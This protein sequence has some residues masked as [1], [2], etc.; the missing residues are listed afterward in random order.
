MIKRIIVV[1][2]GTVDL[3]DLQETLGDDTKI[4]V[5][6]Q[7]SNPPNILELQEPARYAYENER[8]RNRLE[9]EVSSL[10][11]RLKSLLDENNYLTNALNIARDIICDKCGKEGSE[12]GC[13]GC[14]LNDTKELIKIGRDI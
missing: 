5:Y 14:K 4:I 1:E 10:N 7:G 3:D 13:G 2:D 8:E 12:E 11:T 6:R 9:K